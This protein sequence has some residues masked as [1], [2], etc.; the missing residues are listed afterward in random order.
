MSDGFDDT[1]KRIAS[2]AKKQFSNKQYEHSDS[3]VKALSTP[4][5]S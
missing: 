5:F 1:R 2:S 4:D 3:E